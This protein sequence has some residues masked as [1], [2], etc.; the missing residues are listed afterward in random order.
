MAWTVCSV[1]LRR[2]VRHGETEG[3]G[4]A[5]IVLEEFGPEVE[6]VENEFGEF[7]PPEPEDIKVPQL[8]RWEV[9]ELM[10]PSCLS[11]AKKLLMRRD[12]SKNT[13]SESILR[14]DDWEDAIH[15]R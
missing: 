10:C 11:V 7:V 6:Y 9:S 1:C 14:G 15:E 5:T 12:G 8:H 3:W 4:Q 2:T 13:V